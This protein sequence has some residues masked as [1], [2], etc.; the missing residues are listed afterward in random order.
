M[1]HH[2]G[3]EKIL[4]IHDISA[5]RN[6]RKKGPAS[7]V[8][9]HGSRVAVIGGG[10]AG[11][12]FSYF[13]LDMAKRNDL[14]I[15]LNIYE[16]KD[17][18]EPGPGGCNMCGG[19]IYESLIQNLAVEGINLPPTV[20]QRGIEYN[21]LHMDLG[22][23]QIQTPHHEKR[24]ATTFRG[25][26]PRN[27]VGFQ[28]EGLDHYLLNAAVA[29]GARVIPERIQQVKWVDDRDGTN[30]GDLRP[31]I[32]PKGGEFI[33]Y[34]FLAVTPGVNSSLLKC[35]AKLDPDYRPPQTTKLLVREYQLGEGTVSQYLGPVFHGF[36][37]DIPG[38]DY[39]A[40]IPKGEVMTVCLLSSRGDL[41]P[42]VMN[43]FL[44]DPA[45]KRILPP[46][47]SIDNYVCHCRPRINV[48][49]CDQP[50]GDR[51]VFIGDSGVSRLY[52]DG[53]GAAYKTAKIAASTAV[54]QGISENDFRK[55]FLPACR[56]TTFDNRIGKLIFK[57]ISQ[58]QDHA[59]ARKAVL[60]M[61]KFEQQGRAD[62]TRGMSAIMW[63]M[64]TGGAPYREVMMRALHP[65]F[66]TQFLKHL[67][68]SLFS[69]INRKHVGE[70]GKEPT[71]QLEPDQS[72]GE[73]DEMK[74]SAL[75]KAYKNG[76]V[77][78]RQGE[79]GDCMY[80]V[81][82]GFVEVI[83]ESEGQEV[84]LNVLGKDDFFGEMAIFNQK[85]R[86][87]TVRARGSARIL[88]VNH[89]NLLKY[90]HEDP[91]LAYRLMQVMSDRIDRLSEAVADL[92]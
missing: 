56:R 20:V 28:G 92:S 82:D 79:P 58:M 17:F 83:F 42:E 5:L 37:L 4:D 21:M 8:L 54:F 12:F 71:P 75:G 88:T 38:L 41:D 45:V 11:S 84:E 67:A 86:T 80:V 26:G 52:K 69:S 36:L 74:I 40:I 47:F 13:L 6:N 63:D 48:K 22:S 49:G 89:K 7:L 61:V 1:L 18:N 25:G 2:S 24:I 43:I 53:I 29:K 66:W 51:L 44:N 19:V 32:L 87:A 15:E 81:Q 70:A 90:I 91:S 64:L 50:Y 46:D 68:V 85:V 76:E 33:V 14:K 9:N 55:H 30:P 62:S 16:P 78:V 65:L 10:P 39:G 60:E 31:A 59:F 57:L 23:A 35:F 77:I 34:D 3:P 27:L 72:T 73:D